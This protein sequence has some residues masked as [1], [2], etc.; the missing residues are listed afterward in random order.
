MRHQGCYPGLGSGTLAIALLT[1]LG[2]GCESEAAVVSGGEIGA[3]CGVEPCVA[4][5]VCRDG[6]CLERADALVY[7]ADAPPVI[8]IEVTP[9]EVEVVSEVVEVLDGIDGIDD[10]DDDETDADPGVTLAGD[11][12]YL[13]APSEMRLSLGVSQMAVREIDV[14]AGRPEYL[15]VYTT[16]LPPLAGCARFRVNLWLPDAAGVFQTFASWQAPNESLLTD[17]AGPQR[18]ELGDVVPDLLAGPVRVGLA[19][20]GPC[21]DTSFGP[22]VALDASG[23]TRDSYVWAGSWIPG[24]TLGLTG[25]WAFRLAVREGL[26]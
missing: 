11:H 13:T 5:L 26:P 22:W 2:V 23:E 19:Y 14:P 3:L 7:E 12:D 6:L 24:Q 1:V 16:T 4:G 20:L 17:A 15:E 25:R 8:R 10:I 18:A 9:A 21:D